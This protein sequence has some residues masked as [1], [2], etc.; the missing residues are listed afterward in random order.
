MTLPLT[1][2]TIAVTAIRTGHAVWSFDADFERI[3]SALDG[4][5]LYVPV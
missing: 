5:E 1:D 4:L 3:A 2:A